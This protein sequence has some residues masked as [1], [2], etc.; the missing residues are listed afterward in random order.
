MEKVSLLFDPAIFSPH[1]AQQAVRQITIA[2]SAI[3]AIIDGVN[4]DVTARISQVE[5]VSEEERQQICQWNWTNVHGVEAFNTHSLLRPETTIHALVTSQASH[6]PKALAVDAWDGRLS[7][8]ELDA[9]ATALAQ[10]LL[11]QGHQKGQIV[12]LC[13]EK[14][15]WTVVAALATLKA[16][17]VVTF[18]DPSYPDARL[19]AI[20][21]ASSATTVLVAASHAGRFLGKVTRTIAVST[22]TQQDLIT[23]QASYPLLSLPTTTS[24]DAA[25]ILFTSGSTGVPKGII[26]SHRAASHTAISSARRLNIT[27]S[28]RVLQFSG[29][30]FDVNVIETC[31]ALCAGACL[32]VSSEHDRLNRLSQS[33][34]GMRVDFAYLTPST[35]R[36][37]DPSEL[38]S[39]RTVVLVGE[40][41]PQDVYQRWMD[42]PVRLMNGYGPAECSLCAVCDFGST[43]VQNAI[44]TPLDMTCWIADRDEPNHLAPLGVVG[45]LHFSGPLLADG[46]LNDEERT[47]QRFVQDL[48]YMDH[49]SPPALMV[50]GGR[51]V[52]RTGDLAR[53]NEDG[54]LIFVGRADTMVKL[55]GQRIELAE[56]EHHLSQCFGDRLR[57]VVDVV[58]PAG[59]RDQ[60]PLLT[61]FVAAAATDGVSCPEEVHFLRVQGAESVPSL[62]AVRSA[63]S[64]RLPPY[65][66]PQILLSLTQLPMTATQKRDRKRLK[67][68]GSSLSMKEISALMSADNACQ[69]QGTQSRQHTPPRT[70]S[71][72]LL[73]QLWAAVLGID[74][75]EIG[76]EDNF[77][78]L[79]ADSVSVMRLAAL[80]LQKGQQ[81]L[82][83]DI[84]QYPVLETMSQFMSPAPSHTTGRP[85]HMMETFNGGVDTPLSHILQTLE[86]PSDEVVN[87]YPCT[88]F[89]EGLLAVAAL[90]PHSYRARFAFRLPSSA[91]PAAVDGAWQA[92]L[93]KNE[94]LRT[95]F[96]RFPSGEI[97]QIVRKTGRALETYSSWAAYSRRREESP[98]KVTM[99]ES[100]RIDVPVA[101]SLL[102]DERPSVLILE[103]HHVLY[104]GWSLELLLHQ[105]NLA[106]STDANQP[107]RDVAPMSRFVEYVTRLD[108]KAALDYWKSL[109]AGSEATAFPSLPS[110]GYSAKTNETIR[111]TV[112]LPAATNNL[113]RSCEIQLAWAIAVAQYT[114]NPDVSFGLT[115]NGRYAPLPEIM[116]IAGPTICAVPVRIQIGPQRTLEDALQD[117]QDQSTGRVPFEQIGLSAI[118]QTSEDAAAACGFQTLMVI[119]PA[120]EAIKTAYAGLGT[121][122]EGLSEYD[123]SQ[124]YALTLECTRQ[125]E[126]IEIHARYDK[127]VVPPEEMLGVLQTFRSN[128]QAVANSAVTP[129]ASILS[130]FGHPA[131]E[132]VQLLRQWNGDEPP[133]Y[134]RL[135]HDLIED[136][137]RAHPDM[138]AVEAWDGNFSY[139]QL[140]RYANGVAQTLR[141]AVPQMGPVRRLIVPVCFEKSAWTVVAML[142]IL[143]AGHAFCMLDPQ[144]PLPRLQSIVQDVDAQFVLSSPLHESLAL[145]LCPNVIVL[146]PEH[147]IIGSSN[148]LFQHQRAQICQPSDPAY[149][150]F[151]SGS[152]GTPKGVLIT[153]SAF[154]SSAIAH[155]RGFHIDRASRVLQFASYAFDAC[156][157]EILTPLMAGG[158]VCVLSDQQRMNELTSATTA[159]RATVAFFTPSLLRNF[160]PA[161]LPSLKT[162]I[163]NGEAVD[164]PV[165]ATWAPHCTIVNGYGPCECSVVCAINPAVDPNTQPG[166]IGHSVGGTC[167][168]VNPQDHHSL[169]PIGAVGELVVEGPIVGSGYLKRPELT[170]RLFIEPPRWLKE[171]RNTSPLPTAHL[172]K[173]GD[174][175]RQEF[176]G[177]MIY[178]GRKDTQVKIR[179]QRVELQEI[180]TRII[181]LLGPESTGAQVIVE[182]IKP[183]ETQA[184][185]AVCLVAFIQYNPGAKKDNILH[186]T[187]IIEPMPE[188]TWFDLVRQIKTDLQQTL[189]AYMIPSHFVPLVR[190]PLMVSKKVDRR[191]LRES[192]QKLSADAQSQLTGRSSSSRFSN[193]QLQPWS[194]I[195]QAL[196]DIW[197]ETLR[198]TA[199][200]V[201]PDDNFFGLGGDSIR[202]MKLVGIARREGFELSVP[203][204]LQN[205]TIAQLVQLLTTPLPSPLTPSST[206]DSSTDFDVGGTNVLSSRSSSP[207]TKSF[208]LDDDLQG[209]GA[210]EAAGCAVVH[211]FPATDYQSVAFRLA[212]SKSRS[213]LNHFVIDL[214]G[215]LDLPRLEKACL[216]LIDSC[217]IFRTVFASPSRGDGPLTQLV[218]DHLPADQVYDHIF[219]IDL[220]RVTDQLIW[221]D[222]V[223]GISSCEPLVKITTIS[224]TTS[225]PAD[226]SSSGA[227]SSH[228]HRILIK[229][230]HTHYDGISMPLVLEL[231]SQFYRTGSRSLPVTNWSDY[232][233]TSV[234]PWQ[235]SADAARA[236]W[237][238]YL[239]GITPIPPRVSSPDDHLEPLHHHHSTL[240]R[241]LALPN[242]HPDPIKPYSLSSIIEAAWAITLARWSGARD[243][244]F[245]RLS[246]GRADPGSE[247]VVGP[248]LVYT[249][250]RVDFSHHHHHQRTFAETIR[251]IQ[252]AKYAGLP[253]ER[254]GHEGIARA[255]GWPTTPPM[256]RFASL[257]QHQNIEEAR[258]V[259]LD[260]GLEGQVTDLG[261]LE[262]A[263][264]I[265]VFTQVQK[266]GRIL[267]INLSAWEEDRMGDRSK[268]EAV[269]RQ[270]GQGL[271]NM[272]CAVLEEGLDKP[273]EVLDF[274]NA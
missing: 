256:A 211:R 106:L 109:L 130:T 162:I 123:E 26:Q 217:D 171:F 2:I 83:S 8:E 246:A 208:C 93:S 253:Y 270:K 170:A 56:V 220:A 183:P 27:P 70:A 132:H 234:L 82:A 86:V 80:A 261:P 127:G 229:L 49:V 53:Y 200:D 58:V 108:R 163:L 43:P 254:L 59:N 227:D 105:L 37:L 265:S 169:V 185:A 258:T 73:Q 57:W 145:S 65:M 107:L 272:L 197:A 189:P 110:A 6:N 252:E 179:G 269:G 48:T 22:E 104:D 274:S 74:V 209:L 193:K 47:H 158:C 255:C 69:G 60:Q 153:H 39:L 143:K 15:R 232:M 238:K 4:L 190:V 233:T 247:N 242:P 117:L 18:M 165:V 172:Y 91:V 219:A 156:L 98:L 94:I 119:Q 100:G 114:G 168:V 225:F 182:A 13:F 249:P 32:C 207:A 35:A 68:L 222:R 267:A 273:L 120:E 231:L 136:T 41:V 12:P 161:D 199:D 245:W 240:T 206:N 20:V 159:L 142:G 149:V 259:R 84:T 72:S 216:A 102:V 144:H 177:S 9:H 38:P 134:D 271:L 23:M 77:F 5:L 89:Q 251:T 3:S 196:R 10:K 263:G 146:R 36:I 29:Y 138:S 181:T 25:F 173:T 148:V 266:G 1:Q 121:L 212:Q 140:T 115:V 103:L 137:A 205:P 188:T 202:A 99:R 17:G 125:V 44:G 50:D 167:W 42:H 96:L 112:P 33:A 87:A 174:L 221:S 79:G 184:G 176:D 230:I 244:L 61:A 166:N 66:V 63:L 118:A 21:Q 198:I 175:V 213:M 248:C 75:G 11:R 210:L 28:S 150:I 92:V 141:N 191:R 204:L 226:A 128:L 46:Y 186:S 126:G 54:T 236:Y 237:K 223:R 224:P 243:I 131:S 154:A 195:G 45:E 81:L 264:E 62:E 135:I 203:Q 34:A 250:V 268:L 215:S 113:Q 51:R 147:A 241:I 19:Q 31:M 55:R 218:L 124:P 14:S 164:G 214:T 228:P 90:H 239:A 111:L 30:A 101:A 187:D 116:D 85:C 235:A 178:V 139:T 157:V 160:V 76:V 52:F 260:E 64:A 16:G 40:P 201:G 257:V 129:N 180:E 7:Y 24:A 88:P 194:P 71:E 95:T 67:E 151:S 262:N 133:R 192:F 78:F 122:A 152:T 97:A 155:Q